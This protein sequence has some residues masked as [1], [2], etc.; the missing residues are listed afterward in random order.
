MG[1]PSAQ[2]AS[3]RKIVDSFQA[4][5]PV[6]VEGLAKA[7]GIEVANDRSLPGEVSA[8]IERATA[9]GFKVTLNATYDA[10]RRR[11]TLAHA[12]AHIT[13]H[14]DR[15][16]DKVIES[17][18]YR[19]K[20]GDALEHAAHQYALELLM[21]AQIVRRKWDEGARSAAEMALIFG[22]STEAA[23]IHL[24]TLGLRV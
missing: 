5:V 16:T 18:G 4:S 12:I 11:F 8:T 20:L 1:I 3:H 22:V 10:E 23:R 15:I 9:G 24:A 13:L 7:L 14:A 6:D 21:P 2:A 17:R 19:S